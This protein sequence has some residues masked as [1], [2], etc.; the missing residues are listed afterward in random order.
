MGSRITLDKYLNVYF[1]YD[2]CVIDKI[3]AIDGRKWNARAKCWQVP[4]NVF[5]Y[6]ALQSILPKPI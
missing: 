2:T 6:D 4:V 5:N 1:N 3:R